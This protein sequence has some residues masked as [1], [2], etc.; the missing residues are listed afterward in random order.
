MRGETHARAPISD[1]MTMSAHET[2]QP[3]TPNQV[4]A[5]ERRRAGHQGQ[6]QAV[7]PVRRVEVARAATHRTGG[8]PEQV[9][10]PEP[11]GLAACGRSR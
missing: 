5:I 1:V 7:A 8:R 6:A 10:E 2:N 9:G 3:S 4:A 11:D